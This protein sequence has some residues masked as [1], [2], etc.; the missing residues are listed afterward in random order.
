MSLHLG[1]YS[2]LPWL[3]RGIANQLQGASG[4][5]GARATIPVN[6][7]LE[8]VATDNTLLQQTIQRD[9]ALYGP[10][11]I[12]GIDRRAIIKV[13]PRPTI[14]NFE[15]NYLPYI[16]FYDEDFPWRYSPEAPQNNRLQPWIMLVV[17]KESEFEEGPATADRPLP[18]IKVDGAEGI[19]PPHEQ[20]WAWAHVHVNRDLA[21][22]P[23]EMTS[24]NMTAVM[25]KFE[26]ALSENPDLGYSRIL[27]PRKLDVSSTYHAF[28]MPTYESG[29]LAGL[30]LNPADTPALDHGAWQPDTGKIESSHYPYYHRWSFQTGT[31]GDFEYLV[32]LLE[33]RP[34]DSRVG[35]R[36]FDVQDPGANLSPITDAELNG[37]LRL[38]GALRVPLI[39]LT[40]EERTEFDLYNDWDQTP[41]PH[42]FQE[43]L[44]AFVNLADDYQEQTA[45]DAHANTSFDTTIPDPDDPTSDINDPDPLIT[46][47]LYGRWHALTSRLLNDQADNPLTP[48]DN[49]VHQLNLDPRHR[50]AAGFGT[51]VIKKNQELYM[52]TAWEQVGEILSAIRLIRLAQMA[53]LVTGRIHSRYVVPLAQNRVERAY[54]LTA[55]VQKR[56][57]H[58]GQTAHYQ[59]LTSRIPR[60]ITSTTA[61][62]LLR[63]RGRLVRQL[64]FD[65]ILS[66]NTLLG[67]INSGEVT[68]TP[69]KAPLSGAPSVD[70][71]AE[72][73]APTNIPPFVDDLLDRYPQLRRWTLI[74]LIVLI[75]LFPFCLPIWPIALLLFIVISALGYV[76]YQLG[77]WEKER[78]PAESVRE[79]NQKPETVDALP[80]SP[81]FRLIDIGETFTPS[82]GTSDS[83]EAV[84]FKAALKETYT[85]VE[86]TKK[87]DDRQERPPL[88]LV[89][90]TAATVAQ[91]D[92]KITIPR[93]TL[94]EVFI[95]PRIRDQIGEKFVEPMAY[96][97][98]D[99]PMYKPL[100]DKSEDN[101]LPNMQFIE[102]NTISLLETNQPFIEAYMVG[103]NHEFS[104]ELLWREYPTDQ[105]GTYFRQF[106]DVKSYLDDNP[107]ADPA[108]LREKLRDIPPL[109]RWPRTSLLGD[110]DHRDTGESEDE[111]VLVIRGE[112]LKKYPNAVIY[113]HRARW[114]RHEDGT[115]NNQAE[116]RLDDPG[117]A[118]VTH[119]PR[120]KVKTPLYEAKVDPDITFF[121]FDLTAEEA[122]GGSGENESDDPGWFFVLKERPGEP[123]FG[124]DIGAADHLYVWNDLGWE[125]IIPNVKPGDFLEIDATTPTLILEALPASEDEQA[126][127]AAEDVAVRWHKDT[128]AA[129]LAYILYQVPVLVAVHAAE[130]LPRE[131]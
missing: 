12:V 73:V 58:M 48:N 39:A 66:V 128:D 9:V 124:L 94:N 11:D 24:G 84:N 33:P 65:D 79:A 85:L 3:R 110:H 114:Q 117:A 129:E 40:D 88:D 18:F 86:A 22:S 78:A 60:A 28:L 32:R 68:A 112:L 64:P 99:K 5:A 71:L 61:R 45:P 113:A 27:C 21:A 51:E 49:W 109:H 123:R 127:Q 50:L 37:V 10:G 95:P 130:M 44:A 23:T 19:F 82:P 116:R 102:Q 115:I 56:V 121:G 100:V 43:D 98:I 72:G 54:W 8:G 70:D 108:A 92:P 29:R 35:R 16:D 30:G 96:P 87:T 120:D 111:V 53:R 15:P 47:P 101:F 104:R 20:L 4:A 80:Q 31:I 103:L 7:T 91:I 59:M 38:G 81:D 93:H 77:R 63:P 107:G 90:V 2:F 46:P 13:E 26:A 14:T 76:Y 118:D 6:L 1:S 67:R 57:L 119:P 55:P 75:I 17:L 34:V 125:N 69:P 83:P 52:N 25:A 97:V 74:A 89:A 106:W 42:P 36:D 62:R 126:E 122:Q 131:N 41:Y 105:R